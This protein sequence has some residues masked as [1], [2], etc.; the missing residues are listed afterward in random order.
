MSGIGT[1]EHM[2]VQLPPLD[3]PPFAVEL[4]SAP[5]LAAICQIFAGPEFVSATEVKAPAE[6]EAIAATQKN[7]ALF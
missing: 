5:P 7:I 2:S 1:S 6:T 4:S 3:A